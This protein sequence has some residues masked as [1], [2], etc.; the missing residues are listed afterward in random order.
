M[1]NS[2]GVIEMKKL[3]SLFLALLLC[4]GCLMPAF[5]EETAETEQFTPDEYGVYYIDHVVYYS[6]TGK[7]NPTALSAQN[8]YDMT[9]DVTELVIRDEINGIPV[10][11]ISGQDPYAGDNFANP[12]KRPDLSHVKKVVV[13]KNVS[14]IS[15]YAF[16]EMAALK[17]VE[18]KGAL[19]VVGQRAFFKCKNLKEIDLSNG[20]QY[21]RDLAFYG[22]KKLKTAILP[23]NLRE[24]GNKAFAHTG[25]GEIT[26]PKRCRTIGSYAFAYCP[27]LKLLTVR[28]NSK[29]CLLAERAFCGDG[30]LETVKFGKNTALILSNEAFKNCTALKTLTLPAKTLQIFANAL[31][32]LKLQK[33]RLRMSDPASLRAVGTKKNV[34]FA[35]VLP[36]DCAAVVVNSEMKQALK[37]YGWQGKILINEKLA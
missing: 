12:I 30:K 16:G 19:R 29:Y 33:I 14:H 32:G 27:K 6:G 37:A 21:I 18:I 10:T 2:K 34:S 17:T 15:A 25:L 3:I 7:K 9:Q 22:C 26:V 20:V 13:G 31:S 11:G 5:A 4:L 1:E 28:G 8:F 36:N 23:D 35:N 24:I